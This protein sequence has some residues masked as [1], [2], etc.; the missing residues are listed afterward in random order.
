MVGTFGIG[1]ANSVKSD[2]SPA[3]DN[4]IADAMCKIRAL[5]KKPGNE[6]AVTLSLRREVA[7][8]VEKGI[9]GYKGHNTKALANFAD[10]PTYSK[11]KGYYVSDL[12]VA[13]DR[14]RLFAYVDNF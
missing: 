11:K 12:L 7:E 9:N 2:V 8:A 5:A 14:T 6:G 10:D 4:E 1:W 3:T 13:R